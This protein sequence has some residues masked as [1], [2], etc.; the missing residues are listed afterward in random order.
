MSKRP[1]TG[2][3]TAVCSCICRAAD[4]T[5]FHARRLQEIENRLSRLDGGPDAAQ[6]KHTAHK[7]ENLSRADAGV[8]PLC[9][10]LTA[11]GKARWI[12]GL[13]E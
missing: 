8:D 13:A 10:S 3:W 9:F 5:S 6:S 2:I 4:L 11:D 12:K 7:A 1:K